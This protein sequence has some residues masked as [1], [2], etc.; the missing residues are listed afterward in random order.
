MKKA[1]H[2][3]EKQEDMAFATCDRHHNPKVRVLELMKTEGHTLYFAVSPLSETYA[4]LQ[5]NDRAEALAWKGG[6]SVRL[7]GKVHFDVPDETCRD[8]Y[9]ESKLL[10][11]L[12]T[13]YKELAY[14]RFVAGRMVYYDLSETPPIENTFDFDKEDLPVAPDPSVLENRK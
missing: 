4:Q 11:R 7:E 1:F 5:D 2:F 3:L 13:S 9:N 12:Y 14:L 6:I 10:Q 8:I